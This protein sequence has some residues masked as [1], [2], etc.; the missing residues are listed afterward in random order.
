MVVAASPRS[1]AAAAAGEAAATVALE[2]LRGAVTQHSRG[3]AINT[4]Q[5]C[6]CWLP[7][8]RQAIDSL[9]AALDD[10]AGEAKEGTHGKDD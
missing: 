6:D 9:D 4:G 1:A 8:R 10:A 2:A 5:D 3:C 7:L